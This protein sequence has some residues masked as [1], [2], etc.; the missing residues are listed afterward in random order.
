MATQLTLNLVTEQQKVS[1][2]D[3]ACLMRDRAWERCLWLKEILAK[4]P[5]GAFVFTEQCCV[6]EA[7]GVYTAYGSNPHEWQDFIWIDGHEWMLGDSDMDSIFYKR[8]S[9]TEFELILGALKRKRP[10]EIS[11]LRNARKWLE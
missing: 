9:H 11:K 7:D 6:V 5:L 8:V 2:V 10:M 1:V 4:L 3:D